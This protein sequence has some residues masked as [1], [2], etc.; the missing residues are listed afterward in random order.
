[1]AGP[2][3]LTGQNIEDTYQ[4]IIQTDGSSLYDG[5]GSLYVVT[6]VAA[7]AGPINSIQFNDSG[8]TSGS[9]DFTFNKTTNVVSL[10]GSINAEYGFTG[11]LFGTAATASNTPNALVTGSIT[12]NIIT[13]TKGNGTSFNLT[14]D[15]GSVTQIDTSSFVTTSSFNN[16]TSSYNTGSF[17]GSF[18][19]IL[20]GTASWAVSASYAANG[21]L[22]GTSG[23]ILQI[24]ID[25]Q[26]QLRTTLNDTLG[27]GS[28]DFKRRSLLDSAGNVSADYSKRQLIDSAGN[29]SVDFRV[30]N[31][32]Y[33]DG[34][35]TSIDYSV[36]DQTTIN[37]F[38]LASGSFTGSLYGT[39]SWAQNAVT[40]SFAPDYVLNS[41]T[42]SFIVNS[43]T[44]SFVQ[45]SVTS[46][47]LAPY[48]L[49]SQTSSMS[50]ATASFV[51]GSNVIGIV[52]S[53]SYAA[54][55]GVTRIIAGTNVTIS[56]TNGLGT[57]TI[58]SSGGSGG[59][60]AASNLFNYYN[61]I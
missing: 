15:T 38:L 39:A 54:N 25:N 13:L 52:N 22:Q 14:V 1:M 48:V 61:F 32:Y 10:T 51:T 28:V 21:M 34:S 56:P 42:S 33:P 20:Y 27:T 46:S 41:A 18:T 40:A 49:S 17:T 60:S 43:Q 44:S 7:P 2:L 11:S 57:V 31:L 8:A 37:G 5:T 36:Q 29:V 19:G 26:Y 59:S 4:R 6:A 58:N 3:N 12:G 55:G 50:V 23:Q 47:M 45:N 53:A 9:G 24:D 35:T 16:F 30:R